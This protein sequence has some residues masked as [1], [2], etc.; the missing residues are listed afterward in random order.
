M[1]PWRQVCEEALRVRSEADAIGAWGFSRETE[2]GPR[3][4]FNYRFEHTLAVV[5]TARWLCPLC[6]AD[7]ETVECAAWL[8]DVRKEMQRGRAADFHAAEASA[9]V[10]GILA[11]TDF[12]NA[13]IPAVRHAIERHVG[14]RLAVPLEPLE[15]AALWDCDKLSKIGAA[16]LVHFACIA[17]AFHP[18]TTEA[19][20][21][22]GES[23]LDL[24]EG[25][26]A[27]MNTAPARVE[28]ARRL[29]FLK[30][31]YAQLRR[32][33]SDPMEGRPE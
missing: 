4:A 16:S 8:H 21:K 5:R 23:W 25:I 10:E 29:E 15:T 27:S 32:E 19:I 28:A 12:P 2:G 9:A 26:A 24:A 31:H 7:A 11:G 14:L 22:R 20:L 17:A 18:V 33:W 1:L 6:G 3:A 13:K 30:E